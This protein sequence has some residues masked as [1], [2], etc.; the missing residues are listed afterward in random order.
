[1]SFWRLMR[2]SVAAA[3]LICKV[4]HAKSREFRPQNCASSAPNVRANDDAREARRLIQNA[5]DAVPC[6]RALSGMLLQAL[7]ACRAPKLRSFGAERARRT[8]EKRADSF[9]MLLTPCHALV[10]F[11]ECFSRRRARVARQVAPKF[12]ENFA[13]STENHG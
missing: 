3:A 6:T 1:M 2:A 8:Q 7:G 5:F 4:L 9:Q 10:R 13:I 11:Q 12:G